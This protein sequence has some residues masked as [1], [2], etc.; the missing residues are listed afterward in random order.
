MVGLEDK[1]A[2]LMKRV[3]D[4]ETDLSKAQADSSSV[5]AS[6]VSIDQSPDTT[7][8]VCKVRGFRVGT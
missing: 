6:I 1:I 5:T 2:Q 8:K 3:T 7:D 4:L